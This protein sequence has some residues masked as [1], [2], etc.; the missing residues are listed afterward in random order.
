MYYDRKNEIWNDD[1]CVESDSERCVKM[2]CHEPDT[3]FSLLGIFKE[4]DYST[5]MEQVVQGQGDC[6]WTDD[7][8]K[9]MQQSHESWPQQCTAT[10]SGYY[11]DIKPEAGGNMGVG[12]YTDPQCKYEYEGDTTLD[13]VMGANN[14]DDTYNNEYG[15][16]DEELRAWNEAFDAFKI[17]QPCRAHDL[18]SI[19]SSGEV[20]NSDGNRYQH[21]EQ[22]NERGLED[23]GEDD[24]V[25]SSDA[26]VNQCM[27]FRSNTNMLTAS[28]SD[29][30]LAQ[31][32]GT[33]TG[34][35]MGEVS[36]GYPNSGKQKH[37]LLSIFLLLVA[38]CCLVCSIQRYQ[39]ARE[40]QTESTKKMK[41][42]FLR[43]NSRSQSA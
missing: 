19:M 16:I 15:G 35:K 23:A 13:R 12:L 39:K 11:Y 5:W 6:L 7:E 2:D 3:H 20:S 38:V 34:V 4:P 43:R 27:K 30:M 33:V 24:F 37:V 36:V 31:K 26:G 41:E 17:C 32:Q 18:V 9:F 25:C 40:A 21:R 28:F 42:P 22:E 29:V 10:N 8:Y 14:D 1:A